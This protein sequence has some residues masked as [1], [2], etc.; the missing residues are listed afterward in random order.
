MAEGIRLFLAGIGLDAGDPNL[1]NTPRRVVR[2]WIDEFLSGYRMD[3]AEILDGRFPAPGSGPVIVTNLMFVSVCP[4]HL[5]PYSGTAHLA[6]LPGGDVVGL[7]QLSRLVDCF[8]RRLVLQETLTQQIADAISQHLSAP[9]AACVLVS[10]Q[11]C[12]ALRG[13]RQDQHRCVTSAYV[14]VFE[15]DSSLKELLIKSMPAP[16]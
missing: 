6:Y 9:G 15:H 12:M 11:A 5:L 7:S 3:P 10:S 1:A 13:V 16:E 4:H 2:A 8:A 14:G